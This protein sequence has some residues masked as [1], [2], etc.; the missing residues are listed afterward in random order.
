MRRSYISP[1]FEHRYQFGSY[2]MVEKSSFFGSKM[3]E[4]EDSIDISVQDIIYYQ[5]LKKEQIDSDIETSLPPIYY[6]SSINKKENHTISIDYSQSPSQRE[7]NTMYN[8]EI[9]FV[10]IFTDFLFATIK[11]ARTFEGLKSQMSY[12]GDVD[13][14]IKEYIDKNILSRY[15][16]DRIDLYLSYKDL[17]EQN[18]LMFSNDWNID[19][20]KEENQLSRLQSLEDDS[21]LKVNFSQ[22]KPSKSFSFDYYFNLFWKKI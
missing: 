9:S 18:V 1:E 13:F 14:S 15:K 6:S 10:K 3:L 16:F 5:N 2:N 19:V 17:R 22:E 20:F 12:Y 21:L 8:L 7:N 11:D 4:I